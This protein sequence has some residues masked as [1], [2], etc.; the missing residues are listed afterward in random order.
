MWTQILGSLF[1]LPAKVPKSPDLALRAC[2]LKPKTNFALEG[3]GS[4]HTP[5]G[6]QGRGVRKEAQTWALSLALPSLQR[7]EMKQETAAL[8]VG[9]GVPVMAQWLTNPTRNH[10]V[11]GPIPDLAH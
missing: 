9:P 8:K 1:T 11:A 5:S 3:A 7:L 10:K 4:S 2:G 6:P